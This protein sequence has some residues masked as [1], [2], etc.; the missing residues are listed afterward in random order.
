MNT[1]L[2]LPAAMHRLTHTHTE[3]TDQRRL[4]A[5]YRMTFINNSGVAS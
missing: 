4:K 5:V 1:P 3:R 2:S